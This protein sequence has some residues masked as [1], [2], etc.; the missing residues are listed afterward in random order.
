MERGQGFDFTLLKSRIKEIYNDEEEFA[1]AI[2]MKVETLRNKLNNKSEFTSN[3]IKRI[4]EL[5]NINPKEI[6]HYFF[7]QLV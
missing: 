6:V 2:P 1:K 5:L 4:V 7:I 3:D